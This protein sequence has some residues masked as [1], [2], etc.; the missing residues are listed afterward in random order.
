MTRDFDLINIDQLDDN[1]LQNYYNSNGI[2]EQFGQCEEINVDIGDD[3]FIKKCKDNSNVKLTKRLFKK[4]ID[5]T[6]QEGKIINSEGK[7][8]LRIEN[9]NKVFDFYP[10]DKGFTKSDGS[11]NYFY[12]EELPQ[13]IKD[14]IAKLEKLKSDAEK[15]KQSQ[16]EAQKKSDAEKAK[17]KQLADEAER[18]FQLEKAEAEAIAKQSEAK[19]A[20]QK[21]LEAELQS[22]NKKIMIIGGII[23]VS[24]VGF[25]IWKKLKK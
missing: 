13:L 12:F 10:K 7:I 1:V 6:I 25:V 14:N 24:V 4:Y 16:I 22:K 17:A 19:L 8:L 5:G 18:K 9:K 21:R 23:L 11:G 2:K 20:E 3:F 15:A